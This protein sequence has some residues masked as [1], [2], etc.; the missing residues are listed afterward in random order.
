MFDESDKEKEAE[1]VTANP[2][3]TPDAETPAAA[4]DLYGLEPMSEEVSEDKV[5]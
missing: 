5:L 3:A 2:V 1:G 4:I